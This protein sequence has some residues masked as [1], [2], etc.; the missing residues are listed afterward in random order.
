MASPHQLVLLFRRKRSLRPELVP[1]QAIFCLHQ[2][3]NSETAQVTNLSVCWENKGII[4]RKTSFGLQNG[5][6]PASLYGTLLDLCFSCHFIQSWL[7]HS[8]LEQSTN[9][10]SL[11]LK[12]TGDYRDLF[13][14]F[15]NCGFFFDIVA[16]IKKLKHAL[17]RA[18]WVMK[19]EIHRYLWK[20]INMT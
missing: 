15:S 5:I 8:E 13:L 19:S 7:F 14:E 11:T 17:L 12:S 16:I 6:K 10:L 20:K 9:L 2:G 3:A 1:G 18:E 4:T